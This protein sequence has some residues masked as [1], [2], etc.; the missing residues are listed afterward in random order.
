MGEMKVEHVLLFLVGAFLVYHMMGNCGCKR[1][2][3]FD[4]DEQET[5]D[6]GCDCVGNGDC[7]SGWCYVDSGTC[8]NFN[9]PS[10]IL[11]E[12][13]AKALLRR[14]PDAAAKSGTEGGDSSYDEWEA[15]L[16]EEA[17]AAVANRMSI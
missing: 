10:D 17:L 3:G 1:V 12:V 2:E 8:Q 9:H 6:V 14:C 15:N 16:T 11:N 4:C 5:G 13:E 7:K